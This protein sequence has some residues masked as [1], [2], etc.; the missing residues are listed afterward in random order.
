ME[1]RLEN[2]TI[3]FEQHGEGRPLLLLHGWPVD[4]RHKVKDFEPLFKDR[5]GWKRIYPDMPGMGKTPG[6]DWIT[7]QDQM[8]DVLMAFIDAVIPEQHFCVAGTS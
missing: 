8:L 1:C 2:I 4:H 3:Y 5:E 6:V 7:N